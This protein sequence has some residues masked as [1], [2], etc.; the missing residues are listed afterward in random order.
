[1]VWKLENGFELYIKKRFNINKV[2][3]MDDAFVV[4]N[5]LKGILGINTR[6][7]ELEAL[8]FP[9]NL[10]K[11]WFSNLGFAW[12][13]DLPKGRLVKFNEKGDEII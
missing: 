9:W 10:E 8:P 6:I 1:M 5:G 3:T 11:S 4:I 13:F 7:I 2:V 12:F